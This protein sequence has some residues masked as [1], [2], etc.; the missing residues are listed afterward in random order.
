[1]FILEGFITLRES[2]I[3]YFSSLLIISISVIVAIGQC[4]Q[5]LYKDKIYKVWYYL[6]EAIVQ[7]IRIIQY[8]FLICL[9]MEMPVSAFKSTELWDKIFLSLYDMAFPEIIWDFAGFVIVFALYNLILYMAFN[10]ASIAEYMKKREITKFSV[11]SIQHT[12]ILG[13]KNL[14]LIP[15]SFIYILIALQII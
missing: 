4:Y 14:L 11:E 15:V 6:I 12:L 5:V 2:Y 13:Y 9:A 3:L 7:I 10:K 1:L 8:V